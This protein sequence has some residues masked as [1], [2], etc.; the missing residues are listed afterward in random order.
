ML[1]ELAKRTPAI[2]ITEKRI[3]DL[4]RIHLAPDDKQEGSSR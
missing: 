2:K 4:Q 3:G 1:W